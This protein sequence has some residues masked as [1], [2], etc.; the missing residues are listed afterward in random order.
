MK[1]EY[2]SPMFDFTFVEITNLLA[3]S[4]DDDDD[5]GASTEEGEKEASGQCR[6]RYD[7]FNDTEYGSL[8]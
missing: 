1:K 2:L 5:L 6:Q 4:P 3:G 8:W 7:G